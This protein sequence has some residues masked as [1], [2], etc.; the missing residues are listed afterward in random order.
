LCLDEVEHCTFQPNINKKEG[1]TQIS[2][3]DMIKKR[4]SNK[5][6]VDK[7]GSNFSGRFPLIYKEGI[8]KQ[9]KVHYFNGQ[10]KQA[11]QLL[12]Q[13]FNIDFIKMHFYN[14]NLPEAER[15]KAIEKL[16]EKQKQKQKEIKGQFSSNYDDELKKKIEP[17]NTK[18]P[19][20]LHIM[21]QVFYIVKDIEDYKD[22]KKRE[23]KKL[24]NE[25]KLIEQAQKEVKE[26]V[27]GSET[28]TNPHATYIKDKY[29][30]FFKTMMCPLKYFIPYL[31]KTVLMTL[32]Q[33][34]HI[35]ISMLMFLWVLNVHMLIIFLN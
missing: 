12:E 21:E 2:S 20:S 11:L 17:E 23:K 25:L 15:A 32:D 16:L 35:Q 9:A 19:K 22:E 5:V 29:A 1:E 7:M 14:K 34:G 33:D 26:E 18:N 4:A 30:K 3:E 24:E 8:L 27:K 31:G 13:N 10:F 28:K 6:W